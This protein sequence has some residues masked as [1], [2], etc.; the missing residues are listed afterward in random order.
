MTRPTSIQKAW[1]DSGSKR[2]IPVSSQ[3][4]ITDGAAS[5]T[6]G[7]PPICMSA[8][9]AGG[10]P[11]SGLDAN[12]ILNAITAHLLLQNSGGRYRFD[13]SI[14]SAL[15][16]YPIGVV[17]QANDG[18]NEYVNIVEGNSTDFNSNPAAIGSSWLPYAG[19]TAFIAPGSILIRPKNT[20]PTG[21]LECDGSSLSRATYASLYANIGVRYGSVD[22]SHFNI[23]DYRG[24]FLRCWAHGSAIDADRASRT[25]RGDGTTGDAVGTK[26]TSNVRSHAHN[27]LHVTNSSIKSYTE[28]GHIVQTGKM[29]TGSSTLTPYAMGSTGGT[30]S[31]PKNIN[32]M[33]IIK[34]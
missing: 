28:P 32:L 12:G 21:Y 7:V 17:L 31:R 25:D 8:L 20:L 11:P 16:G 34:Y 26:Q 27:Y 33:F 19:N 23:P 15:G 1:A 6:D 30:E 14:V 3:I 9:V 2:T 29:V 4:G 24:Y 5:Y 13:S 10:V 22:S 18:L